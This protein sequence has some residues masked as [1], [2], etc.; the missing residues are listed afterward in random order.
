M[1]AV[2]KPNKERVCLIILVRSVATQSSRR[3]KDI[4]FTGVTLPLAANKWIIVR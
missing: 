4:G 1:D 3:G 2:K